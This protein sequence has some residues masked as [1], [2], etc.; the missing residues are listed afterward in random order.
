MASVLSPPLERANCKTDQNEQG[1][2]NMMQLLAIDPMEHVLPHPIFGDHLTW[3][4][5]QSLMALLVGILMVVMFPRLFK[6]PDSSAPTGARNFF[7]SILEYLRIEVFRP[8]LK[9]HT[10]LFVPFLWT[11]FF[12]IAFCNLL[13][14]IPTSEFF[15]LITGGHVEHLGGTA[16]G[17]ITT[18]ATLAIVAFFFIHFHGINTIARDL[19]KGTYGKHGHHG[20]PGS[21]SIPHEA[22]YE[23]DH[24]RAEALPADIPGDFRALGDPTHHYHDEEHASR[25]QR[26]HAAAKQADGQPDRMSPGLAILAA[27]PLYLWNFAPHPFKPQHG[28]SNAKW[29]VDVPFFL[30]L[31]VLELIGA[32]IK[33]FALCMRL[34]AN[35]VA[36]HVVLAVFIGMIVAIPSFWGQVAVGIPIGLFHLSIQLLELFVALLQAYIFTFLVTLF[37]ASAVAPEH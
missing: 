19:M 13:G 26:V 11:T 31:L 28:E 25:P 24:M 14:C 17:S 37:I 12:F 10:D 21:A 33:P 1:A 16:T 5:N 18:T 34:F 6:T 23:L 32:L 4:T 29:L 30:F 27:V 7:E 15:A 9:E 2:I 20:E 8:A 3:F 35:M 36:G 22:A